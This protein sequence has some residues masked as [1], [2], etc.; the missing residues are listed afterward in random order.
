M[1]EECET[2]E[3]YTKIAEGVTCLRVTIFLLGLNYDGSN[4]LDPRRVDDATMC[5]REAITLPSIFIEIIF[6]TD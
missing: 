4:V 1:L 2:A 6:N 5:K 3:F